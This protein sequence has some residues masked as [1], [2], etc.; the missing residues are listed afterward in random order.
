MGYLVEGLELFIRKAAYTKYDAT[1][2]VRWSNYTSHPFR[3]D[4]ELQRPSDTAITA[5]LDISYLRL[6]KSKLQTITQSDCR[7]QFERVY[8]YHCI[9]LW[10]NVLG[11]TLL[12]LQISCYSLII[13]Y[14]STIS[15]VNLVTPSQ[16]TDTDHVR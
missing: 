2:L 16:L 1:V 7:L 14:S 13:A 15:L 9:I 11:C 4:A 6:A 8:Q 10:N 3:T 5:R 12:P